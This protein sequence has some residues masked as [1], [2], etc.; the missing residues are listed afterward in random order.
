MER[1]CRGAKAKAFALVVGERRQ[2]HLWTRRYMAQHNWE[3]F[4]EY[5]HAGRA[6]AI[7]SWAE[8]L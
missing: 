6:A 3:R 4:C 1:Y 5:F 7:G 2:G 8:I